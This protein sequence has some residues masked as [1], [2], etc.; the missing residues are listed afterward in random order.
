MKTM[1]IGILGTGVVGK[2][3]SK[4]F[5]SYGHKVMIGSRN[6]SKL[7]DWLSQSGE[8]AYTGTFEEAAKFGDIIVLAV[9]GT[10]SKT[11]LESI[12]TDTF[13]GKTVIDATNVQQEW[14]V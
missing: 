8:N 2:S 6:K 4:G 7:S 3:L 11:V 12:P 9:K 1:R 13:K 10:A 14:A 5:L